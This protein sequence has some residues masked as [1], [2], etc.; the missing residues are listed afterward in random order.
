VN[1]YVGLIQK[2]FRK[3]RAADPATV[4]WITQLENLLTQSFTEQNSYD[5]KQGFLRLDGTNTFDDTSFEKILKTATGIS[6]LAKGAKGYVLVGI[7]DAEAT[8]ERL[9]QLYGIKPIKFN[10]FDVVGIEHEAKI[11]GKTLDQYFQMLVDKI[12]KSS[13]SEPLRSY[14]SHNI[15]LVR[16]YDKSVFIIQAMGQEDLSDYSGTYY[17]R[18]GNQLDEIKAQNLASHIRRYILN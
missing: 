14:I 11:L 1:S 13:I 4:H 18:S 3:N 2:N 17:I 10:C 12:R 16:Y 5:F 6:N 9:K 7:S 8:T 15:R